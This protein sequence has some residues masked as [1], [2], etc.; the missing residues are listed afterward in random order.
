M[1]Y[2]NDL[3]H[4]LFI[5]SQCNQRLKPG[6]AYQ[7]LRLVRIFCKPSLTCARHLIETSFANTVR[8]WHFLS[9]REQGILC[10]YGISFRPESMEPIALQLI[11]LIRVKSMYYK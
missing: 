4:S 11:D 2:N 6:Q 1:Q 3:N 8:L 5:F 9:S 7:P 10:D